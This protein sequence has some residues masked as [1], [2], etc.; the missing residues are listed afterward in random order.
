[1]RVYIVKGYV[2][3]PGYQSEI[4]RSRETEMSMG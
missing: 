3:G 4:R 2:H 1:M